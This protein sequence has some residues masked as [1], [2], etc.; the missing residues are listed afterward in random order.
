MATAPTH[1]MEDPTQPNRLSSVCA[2]VNVIYGCNERCSYCV[3]PTTRGSE[4]SRPRDAIKKEVAELVAE[5]Y[6]EVNGRCNMQTCHADVRSR[7]AKE[8]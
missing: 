1:I 4:Q 5:G 3:V 7:C 6:R 2:W 8:T